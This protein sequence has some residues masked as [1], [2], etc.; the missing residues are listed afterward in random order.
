MKAEH[1]H[2]SLCIRKFDISEADLRRRV[3]LPQ[4]TCQKRLCLLLTLSVYSE[5]LKLRSLF[6]TALNKRP[7]LMQAAHF[8]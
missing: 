6:L 1:Q 2:L 4:S 7:P 8:V 3:C 5:S